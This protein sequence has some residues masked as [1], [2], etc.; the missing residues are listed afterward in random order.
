MAQDNGRPHVLVGDLNAYE[1]AGTGPSSHS[2]ELQLPRDANYVDVWPAVHGG[3]EGFTG[4]L[5]RVGRGQPEGYPYKRIDYVW[6]QGFHPDAM[7]RFGVTPPGD[8]GL[9]RSCSPPGASCR[10]RRARFATM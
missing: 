9:T 4:M 10:S 6:L 3:E 2:P 5:N 7:S 1:T 8:G